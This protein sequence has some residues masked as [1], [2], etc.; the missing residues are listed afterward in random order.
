[1]L[2]LW[3]VRYTESGLALPTYSPPARRIPC[4]ANAAVVRYRGSV[5]YHAIGAKY[6]PP[7]SC[8]TTHRLIT[9]GSSRALC[10]VGAESR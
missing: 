5:Y 6:E 7:E 9:S 3:P 1:V 4:C 10:S 8:T 2:A